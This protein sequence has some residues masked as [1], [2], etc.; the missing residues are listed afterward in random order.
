MDVLEKLK[1]ICGEDARKGTPF[2]AVIDGQQW[3]FA[4]NGYAAAGMP[5]EG[6]L[7]SEDCP[8]IA[9]V[10]PK[11]PP[12]H[13]TNIAMLMKWCQPL[14]VQPPGDCKRCDGKGSIR[15]YCSCEFCSFDGKIVCDKCD[16]KGKIPADIPERQGLLLNGGL[17]LD[18]LWKVLSTVPDGVNEI[19]IG[20]A[21]ELEV[22]SLHAEGWLGVVMPLR[23]ADADAPRFTPEPIEVAHG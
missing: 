20:H 16:G 3:A 4:T 12:T 17:A 23:G 18:L 6:E 7:R 10:L 13:N 5:F 21:A 19:R 9:A 2:K 15:H 22:Y 11:Q 1:P 8:N 14:P